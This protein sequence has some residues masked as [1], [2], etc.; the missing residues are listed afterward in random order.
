MT[1]KAKTKLGA[2]N[3]IA[4]VL[5]AFSGQIA[6]VIENSWFNTFVND[7]ISPAPKVISLMVALSAITATLTTLIMGTLS[8][9]LGKRKI[10]ILVSY[11]LWGISTMVFPAAGA[12]KSATLAV[13]AVL[14]LDCLMTFFGSTANDASFN[15]WLTN[16]TDETNRGTVSGIT[17]LFPLLA[18]VVTTIVSG[19]LIEY[20]GYTLFFTSMGLLVVVCGLVGGLLMKEAPIPKVEGERTGFWK[21]VF[22]GF[23]VRAVRENKK[24]FSLYFCVLV[25]AIAEQIC[26]PY[27]IIY[28]TKTLGYSYDVIGVNLG[29]MV[30]LAGICGVFFG[31]LVDS[32]GKPKLLLV[33]L[34]VSALGFLLVSLARD[35]VFL[36]VAIFVRSFGMVAKLITTGA[37]IKDLTPP[38]SAG[39]FQGIRMIFWVLLPM[40]IGPFI[41]ERIITFF[42][43]PVVVDGKAGFLPTHLIFIAAAIVTLIALLPVLGMIRG[44]KKEQDAAQ[45]EA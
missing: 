38:A 44:A 7:V 2:N 26:M 36:C 42:G 8:D 12:V 40:V 15:A 13:V 14:A 19:M 27:Q 45:I 16:V 29:L 22:S 11:I 28:F 31:R 34:F 35:M 9:R 41:G 25:F 24:L 30:L 37:W 10:M 4:I 20:F 39:Q 43:Q 18:M 3:W 5:L 23:S 33:A 6:W 1:P 17:E 32:L 21:Q